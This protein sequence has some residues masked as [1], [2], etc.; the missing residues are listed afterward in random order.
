M[1]KGFSCVRRRL[2]GA[3]YIVQWRISRTRRGNRNTHLIR[4]LLILKWT[5]KI[6]SF[7]SARRSCCGKCNATSDDFVHFGSRM[8][9]SFWCVVHV[10]DD[11]HNNGEI[12]L[13]VR[14]ATHHHHQ[15]LQNKWSN[16]GRMYTLMA[17]YGQ[18]IDAAA[19]HWLMPNCHDKCSQHDLN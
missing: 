9:Y 15:M 11:V 12:K 7:V 14:T 19:Y 2:C 4:L 18:T 16:E 1:E 8:I 6:V 13:C 17:V 10:D 5:R 3:P